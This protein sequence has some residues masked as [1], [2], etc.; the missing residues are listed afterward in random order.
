MQRSTAFYNDCF[1]FEI[2][3]SFENEDGELVWCWLRAGL[4]ELMLQQLDEDQQIT[5][6]PAIGQSWALYLRPDDIEDT[7]RRLRASGVEVSDIEG[8]GYGAREC[9]VTDPDGYALWLSEPESGLGPDDEDS[10]DE[11]DFDDD[12]EPDHPSIH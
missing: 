5:L 2:V 9:F 4:G 12:E 3:D 10:A 6:H 1:G 7:H 8:T 11:D